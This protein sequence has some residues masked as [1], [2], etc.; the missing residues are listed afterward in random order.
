M[1]RIAALVAALACLAACAAPAAPGG[2]PT[3]SSTANPALPPGY[4]EHPQRTPPCSTTSA[5]SPDPAAGPL[6]PDGRPDG[7]AVRRVRERGLRVGVSQTGQFRSKR[8]LVTGELFGLEIDLAKRIA[9]ALGV[10]AGDEGL[11][12]VSLPTG[13]RLYSLDTAANRE[14]RADTALA[15]VPEVDLVIAGVSATPCRVEKYGLLFSEPYGQTH[16]GLLVRAGLTGVAGPDDLGGKKVCSGVS[17]TNSDEVIDER[18]RQLAQRKR[19]LV[20]VAVNDTGDCLM[21][22]QRGFVDAVYSDVLVLHGYRYQD[23]GTVLLDYHGPVTTR[24]AIAASGEQEDL[25][26]FVNAVLHD[27]RADGSLQRANEEW[28]AGLPE[29]HR[30]PLPD[31]P[32]QR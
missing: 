10:P 19:P 22:L 9:A 15:D 1:I 18:D 4:D 13:G 12:L 20:A 14:A 3:A 8:D 32:H 2:T 29:H 30:L 11:R 25:V 6:G 26:R 7:P 5:D 27:M 16:S 24:M 17:T 21:L 23:P 31:D 28:F